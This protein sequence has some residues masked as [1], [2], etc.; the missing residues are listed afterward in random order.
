MFDYF[1]ATSLF[2]LL[3]FCVFFFCVFY[4]TTLVGSWVHGYLTTPYTLKQNEIVKKE[5]R[6]FVESVGCMVH[7]HSIPMNFWGKLFKVQFMC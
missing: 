3:M 6:T 5:N 2:H 4:P 1:Q 7:G